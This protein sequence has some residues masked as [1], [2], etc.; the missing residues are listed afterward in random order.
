MYVRHTNHGSNMTMQ[1][2]VHDDYFIVTS[3]EAD[4]HAIHN[5][6]V[7]LLDFHSKL[8]NQ[9]SLQVLGDQ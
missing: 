8:T 1:M 2:A 4:G 5:Y 6:F 3:N 9:R 7:G